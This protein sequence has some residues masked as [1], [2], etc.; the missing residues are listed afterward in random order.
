MLH[1]GVLSNQLHTPAAH[2]KFGFS[3]K[4]E[5]NSFAVDSMGDVASCVS[6]HCWQLILYKEQGVFRLIP[7]LN[8]VNIFF[9]RSTPCLCLGTDWSWGQQVGGCWCGIWGT[10]DTFS[11]EG[12]RAWSTRPAASEHSP[13]NRYGSPSAITLLLNILQENGSLFASL[14]FSGGLFCNQTLGGGR[15]PVAH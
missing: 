9:G 13:T 12:N 8:T 11:S 10:W 1:E 7:V 6:A 15:L 2:P 4:A 14:Y 3:G 5:G